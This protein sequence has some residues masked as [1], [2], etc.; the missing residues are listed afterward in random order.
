MFGSATV[1]VG[2]AMAVEPERIATTVDSFILERA[3]GE[4]R[5][6]CGEEF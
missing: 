6:G 5:E 3:S 4:F 1:V 2:K